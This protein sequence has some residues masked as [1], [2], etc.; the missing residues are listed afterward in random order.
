MYTKSFI[1]VSIVTL[2]LGVVF[3]ATK[4]STAIAS[5]NTK[6]NVAVWLPYWKVD[7]A[8]IEASE[9]LDVITE[10]SPFAYEVN[11]DGTLKDTFTEDKE[12]WSYLTDQL[13]VQKKKTPIVPSILW[14]DRK[15]MET[16]LNNK[17]KRDA[18]I[19]AIVAEVK[20]KKY[21]GIDIDYEGKS[22]ET[23]VGFSTFLTDLRKQLK[24]S[25]KKLVCTI[26]ART[27]VE[28]RYATVTPELLARIEYANDYKVIGKVC[29]SVRIMTYDQWTADVKLAEQNMTTLYKPVADIDWVKKVLT[30]TLN[31]I[32]AKKIY[33]GVPT[34]GHKYEIL[35]AVGTTTISYSRIGSMN[36]LYADELAKSLHITPTRHV[37][38]ELYFT[39]STT[40]DLY[41]ASLGGTKQYLVWYSDAQAI[42]DKVRIAKLYKLGGVAVFKVDGANDPAMWNVLK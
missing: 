42:A 4:I 22:A 26:E 28:S 32:P 10:L 29:D 36:Y 7:D 41:G 40:T 38:G 16:V 6:L 39:Y 13:A 27:P 11:S 30:L 1:G 2:S 24:K 3:G 15:A 21:A 31:D 14:L 33:V 8:V 25:N 20:A 34:Y 19:K 12:P 23:R 37:S 5:A 18:H 17:K 35:P 9:H